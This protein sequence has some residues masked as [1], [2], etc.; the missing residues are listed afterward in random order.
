M[1]RSAAA[2]RTN[3]T[4]APATNPSTKLAKQCI[5]VI[6]AVFDA[7][8]IVFGAI[9]H[10]T[11]VRRRRQAFRDLPVKM[12]FSVFDKSPDRTRAGG[13]FPIG[14]FEQFYSFVHSLDDFDGVHFQSLSAQ[15]LRRWAAAG[16]GAAPAG[17]YFFTSHRSRAR[18]TLQSSTMRGKVHFD[19]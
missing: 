19:L 16:T 11:P 5:S 8:T 14:H 13:R 1:R 12:G 18:H 10:K 15:L 4:A 9:A 2:T 6:P 3:A 17:F 7:S